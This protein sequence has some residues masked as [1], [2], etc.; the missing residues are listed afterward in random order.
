MKLHGAKPAVYLDQNWLS[1]ITKAQLGQGRSA[2]RNVYLRLFETIQSGIADDRFVCP[3]SLLHRRESMLITSLNEQLLAVAGALSRGLTFNDHA[4]INLR[5][6]IL[7]A[8]DFA[9]IELPPRPLWDI[10][11][12]QDPDLPQRDLAA[13]II[14]EW[15]FVG[16]DQ[17]AERNRHLERSI[18]GPQYCRFKDSAP[19]GASRYNDRFEFQLR[20]MLW[21]SLFGPQIAV[22]M[23]DVV[24][25]GN[26]THLAEIEHETNLYALQMGRICDSAGGI[27]AFMQSVQFHQAPFLST[28]ARLITADIV[29]YRN[30]IPKTSPLTDFAMVSMVL[31]YVTIFATENYMA[32]LIEQTRV[33]EEYGCRTFVMRDKEELIATLEDL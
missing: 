23:P 20:R 5:Q 8:L 16:I 4:T 14:S 21:E 24:A 26:E 32:Q 29:N 9:E 7:A 1:N 18:A 22:Q 19:L 11:F 15:D 25:L 27:G 2:D 28:Y 12:N 10:P 31:P 3:T 33:G 17:A 13:P 6:L 30:S